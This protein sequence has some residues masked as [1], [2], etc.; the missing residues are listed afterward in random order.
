MPEYLKAFIDFVGQN[1]QI[2][3][4]AVF[5]IA[6]SESLAFV[7]LVL[8]GAILMVA[9]GAVIS[10]GALSL[11][12]SLLAAIL[13]AIS[14]DG[15]SYWLGRCY[16][17]RLPSVWL[18]KRHPHLL[19]RGK[20]FFRH[21]GGKSVFLARFVGPVRPVV[22]LVAGMLHMPPLKFTLINLVSAIGWAPVY[23][24]P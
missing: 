21:Y 5:F 2:S 18:F 20:T 14:G 16:K 1:P 22:P 7:G 23:I 17:D 19:E 6:L 11:D 13:G 4:G 3:Y 24:L 10:T 12:I 8:P 15:I 9:V